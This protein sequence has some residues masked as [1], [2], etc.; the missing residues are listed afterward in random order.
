MKL[1]KR[2]IGGLRG[3]RGSSIVESV[4]CILLLCLIMFGL[5]QVFKLS[6]AQMFSD[7]AS[8]CAARA[9]A[10][11]FGG[12]DDYIVERSGQI[13]AIG[14]SGVLVH[15]AT[16]TEFDGSISQFLSE[17]ELIPRYMTG[18]SWLEYK[19]WYGRSATPPDIRTRLNVSADV[20]DHMIDGR[21]VFGDYP[22]DMPMSEAFISGGKLDIGGRSTIMDHAWRYL[23]D[24]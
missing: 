21:A 13:A 2:R 3:E 12:D 22:L 4:L 7:Y 9:R 15:A 14:A 20:S 6:A 8:F 17:V 5:L 1:L 18:E 11:G 16:G 23:G 19:Y 24:D 10:V